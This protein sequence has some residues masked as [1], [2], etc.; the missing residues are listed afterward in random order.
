MSF[1]IAVYAI[2]L[3]VLSLLNL[4]VDEYMKAYIF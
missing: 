3:I 1:L 2:S 4:T